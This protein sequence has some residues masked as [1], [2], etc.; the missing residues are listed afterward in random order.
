MDLN[1]R[2]K[3]KPIHISLNF[4]PSEKERLSKEFY[5]D[6]ADKYMEKIGLAPNLSWS[7]I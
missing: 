5:M 1:V 6:V 3:I 7:T 2:P 4:H